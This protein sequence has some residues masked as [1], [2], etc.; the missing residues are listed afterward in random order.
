MTKKAFINIQD[1]YKLLKFLSNEKKHSIGFLLTFSKY[2][3]LFC[4]TF[5]KKKNTPS[6][7]E[8][9]DYKNIKWH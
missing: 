1:K 8:K 9:I 4:V 7:K 3:K 6:D 2:T 5:R